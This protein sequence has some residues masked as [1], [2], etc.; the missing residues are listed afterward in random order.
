[1]PS[2]NPHGRS[3]YASS[4]IQSERG[5]RCGTQQSRITRAEWSRDRIRNYALQVHRAE[6]SRDRIRKPGPETDHGDTVPQRGYRLTGARGVSVVPNMFA[7]LF[8]MFKHLMVLLL[9]H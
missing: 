2:P 8:S 3:I 9:E 7:D 6:W 1:M 4:E 5:A